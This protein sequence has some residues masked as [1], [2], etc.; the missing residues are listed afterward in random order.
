MKRLMQFTVATLIL[1]C[2]PLQLAGAQS[3]NAP[4]G[5]DRVSSV[6]TMPNRGITM[7]RVENVF[8]QPLRKLAPVGEPPIARWV[9][10]G[11]TVYFEHHIVITSVATAESF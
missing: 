11:F 6:G 9:Y 7:E 8:G 5:G 4:S 1:T 10:D 2:A 3:S